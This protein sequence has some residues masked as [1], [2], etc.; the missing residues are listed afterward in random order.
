MFAPCD[1]II[2]CALLS[3]RLMENHSLPP[4]QLLIVSSE[5]TFFAKGFVERIRVVWGVFCSPTEG[6]MFSTVTFGE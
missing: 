2:L 5:L 4:A 1:P 3:L 6:H